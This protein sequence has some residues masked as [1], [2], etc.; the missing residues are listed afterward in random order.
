MAKKD[1]KKN[2]DGKKARLMEK[3]AKAQKKAEAKNKKLSKKQGDDDL[4]DNVNLEEV[5]SA[6]AKEQENLEKVI[7]E[8]VERPSRRRDTAMVGCNNAGK[9]ELYMF[10]GE[11]TDKDGLVHFYNDLHV[12]NADNDTWKKNLSKTSP[13]PRSSHAMVYHPSGIILLHGGEFSSPKQTTFH[14]FSDTWMLDTATKEWSRVDVR[15]APPSRSGHR[16]TYWKNY[17]ILHGGFNDLGTSTTYLNDVWLF[18]ITTYKWQQVE[19]P[20]NHDVPEARSGHSLIANEEGAIL[21]GGYCKVKAGRGL[22]KGN[23]LVDT[24]TLKMKSDPKGVRWERRRKQGFQPSPRVGCSMQ[25]HKGRG[26][27]FGGVYDYEE[28]EESLDS[29]FYNTLLSYNSDTNRWYNLTLRSPRKV[30]QAAVKEKS[31][32]EDLEDILNEILAKANLNDNEPS[33]ETPESASAETSKLKEDENEASNYVYSSQLPHPRF[34]ATTAVLGDQLYIFGGLFEK[35]EHEFNLYSFYSID[36][37]KL[38]GVKVFFEDLSEL[39]TFREEDEDDEDEDEYDDDDEE[40]GESEDDEMDTANN[41]LE[42]ESPRINQ[43]SSDDVEMEDE[44]AEIPDPTPWLPI[45]KPFESLRSFYVRTGAE[46]LKWAISQNI[47]ARGKQLKTK[48]FELSEERWWERREAI[49]IQE[50]N[51]EEA[52]VTSVVERDGAKGK[53]R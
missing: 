23:T 32:D 7:V 18:D 26:I 48:S 13:S 40:D 19:F 42:V 34:N 44:E 3:N 4:E 36:L 14:H 9:K 31:R 45:P 8:I 41:G 5:I 37:A 22:Q 15:Q 27:L 12:Y 6:L 29:E 33:S 25:Y 20:T 2:K 21:Y 10:G 38:D 51:L 30:K 52:G 49:R 43:N 16:M 46:F 1:N 17:I 11:V 24:W 50:D 47:D 53:R 35:G 39:E 28:T